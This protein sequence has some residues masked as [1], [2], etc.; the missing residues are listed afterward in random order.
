MC[1]QRL[2]VDGMMQVG[3]RLHAA[4]RDMVH[5]SE[6]SMRKKCRGE[7]QTIGTNVIVGG[8]RLGQS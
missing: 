2:A 1:M 7:P 8:I 3:I 6:I 5:G 4:T